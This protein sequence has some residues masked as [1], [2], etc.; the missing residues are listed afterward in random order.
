MPGSVDAGPHRGAELAATFDR[1]WHVLN[2]TAP[3]KDDVAAVV[4]VPCDRC[5]PAGTAAARSDQARL[6]DV[7]SG[8][9]A[10]LSRAIEFCPEAVVKPAR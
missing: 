5:C 6:V 3:V 10:G 4:N 9:L 2:D 7:G 8:Q 1:G